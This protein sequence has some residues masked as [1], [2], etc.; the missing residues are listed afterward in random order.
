MDN[1]WPQLKGKVPYKFGALPCL[2]V[3]G[4]RFR[5]T[6]AILRMLAIRFGLCTMDPV[7]THQNDVIVETCNAMVGIVLEISQAKEQEAY[8]AA[9]D[10]I[11]SKFSKFLDEVEAKMASEGWS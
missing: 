11:T 5:E 1:E 9:E 3:D 10:K 8:Q 2:V 4:K 6:T 7:C